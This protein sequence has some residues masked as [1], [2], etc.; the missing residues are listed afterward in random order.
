MVMD[1]PGDDKIVELQRLGDI[2]APMLRVPLSLLATTD[3]YLK[4]NRK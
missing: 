2:N 1:T 4:A 3:V